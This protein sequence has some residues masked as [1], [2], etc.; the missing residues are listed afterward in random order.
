MAL[1]GSLSRRTFLRR[2]ATVGVALFGGSFWSADP[3][4]AKPKPKHKPKLRH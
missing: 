2:V 4:A 1:D 3:A